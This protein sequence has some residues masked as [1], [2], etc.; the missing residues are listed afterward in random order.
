MITKRMDLW[1]SIE[2]R[3]DAANE[4]WQHYAQK[5][6]K[7]AENSVQIDNED[8]LWYDNNIVPYM[9]LTFPYMK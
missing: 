5:K 7:P 3:R 6:K 8:I 4:N 2:K 1:Y 9:R